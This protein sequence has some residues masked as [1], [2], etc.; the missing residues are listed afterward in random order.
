MEIQTHI[1][2]GWNSTLKFIG[3]SVLITFVCALVSFFSFGILAPV[4]NA[5]Y[6]Q[7][8]LL[9]QREGREPQVKD[10]FSHMS[11]FLPLLLL[12]LVAFIVI[13]IGLMLLVLPGLALFLLLVFGLFYLFPLL[14]DKKMKTIDAIRKSWDMAIADPIGDHVV[15]VVIY[16]ALIALGGSVFLGIF[17]TQPLATFIYL[18]FYEDRVKVS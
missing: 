1:E 13:C 18:S 11:L 4:A 14:T 10:L 9:A 12:G 6:C 7:S 2:K 15:I 3:P 8:L 5:G 17:F 16:M